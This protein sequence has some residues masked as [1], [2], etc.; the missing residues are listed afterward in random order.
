MSAPARAN[1]AIGAAKAAATP[2]Q[3]HSL[4]QHKCACG[5]SRSPLADACE[6]CQSHALQRK[7]LVGSSTDPFELEADRVAEQVLRRQPAAAGATP[8]SIRRVPVHSGVS[9][10]GPADP[11]RVDRVDPQDGSA[12]S[13]EKGASCGTPAAHEQDP[14]PRDRF[15]STGESAEALTPFDLTSGGAPLPAPLR[16]L[17]E[18]RFGRDLGEV[19]LHTGPLAAARTEQLNARAFTYASH[20]WLGQGERPE[21]GFLLAHELAHVIQQRQPAPLAAAHGGA[22]AGSGSA[23]L[24][25]QRRFIKDSVPFWVPLGPGGAM[26]GQ[27]LHNLVLTGAQQ[28]NPDL[29][30]EVDAPNADTHGAGV[31][32]R[33]RIDLYRSAPIHKM[34]GY[35]FDGP[36][37]TTDVMLTTAKSFRGAAGGTN[38][39]FRPYLAGNRIEAL[40]EGPTSVE[41]GELKPASRPMLDAGKDQLKDYQSGMRQAAD[42]TNEWARLNNVRD[43]Q[44]SPAEWKLHTIRN[45]PGSAVPAIPPRNLTRLVV[46]DIRES[47]SR[48][49][50]YQVKIRPAWV[51]GAI[52]VRGRVHVQ[53]YGKDTGLWMYYALPENLGPLLGTLQ[54]TQI[55]GEIEVANAVQDQVID[56]LTQAA[57]Y[58]APLLRDRAD[59]VDRPTVRRKP[60][61][62]QPPGKFTD[63]F[64]LSHWRASRR[65]LHG[66]LEHP[67]GKDK[68]KLAALDL[69]DGVLAADET[70]TGLG[71]PSTPALPTSK[72]KGELI[73]VVSGS[74]TKKNKK[75]HR[76]SLGDLRPWLA[77]WT[78]P[79]SDV[80]GVFRAAFGGMF[81]RVAQLLSGIGKSDLLA[82]LKKRVVDLFAAIK[83][84]ADRSA[85][86]TVMKEGLKWAVGKVADLLLPSVFRMV[87]GAI[88]TGIGKALADLFDR[89]LVKQAHEEFDKW[90]QTLE[91][92]EKSIHSKIDG[93]L[94]LFQE[95]KDLVSK[96]ASIAEMVSRVE[97]GIKWGIRL[98]EC[99]GVWSC[100][101]VLL[102]PVL[103]KLEDKAILALKDRIL[104]ACGVRSLLAGSVRRVL[105]DA[106]VFIANKILSFLH[107]LVPES[108]PPLRTVFAE[109]VTPEPPPELKEMEDNDCWGIDLGFSF[110][111]EGF[112]HNKSGADK[113][114]KDDKQDDKKSSAPPV[115]PG[116]TPPPPKTT[117]PPP[118]ATPSPRTTAPPSPPSPPKTTA[119]QTPPA[120]K[121]APPPPPSAPKQPPSAKP[122]DTSVTGRIPMRPWDASAMKI[123]LGVAVSA[124]DASHVYTA[125]SQREHTRQSKVHPEYRLGYC[126]ASGVLDAQVY[127]WMDEPDRGRPKP[128][129]LPT[130]SIRWKAGKHQQEASDSNPVYTPPTPALTGWGQGPLRPSFGTDFKIPVADNDTVVFDLTLAD[131]DSGVT[132]IYHDSLKV[133]SIPCT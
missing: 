37:G 101:L 103:D 82:K 122:P 51:R 40:E 31:H 3:T 47:G 113:G 32:H 63:T 112:T 6:S 42:L 11:S 84:K 78:G 71:L 116:D 124:T 39:R 14:H 73:N 48:G 106:P 83:L 5:A 67:T 8:L 68:Q 86:L 21:P 34:P 52:D 100:V 9:L 85:I 96:L 49:A 125:E 41:L 114:G 131:K 128:F 75:V 29:D 109:K 28:A 91:G 58:Q 77:H 80:L 90:R 62:D 65:K 1:V 102:G 33:G 97:S 66:Q 46:A 4:F 15:D 16:A 115:A 93:I 35:W 44:G 99:S 133:T 110:F 70:L 12:A 111:D 19:R 120:T 76:R 119:P 54:G 30:R 117:A 98:A 64:V 10:P 45:L 23:A 88:H 57:T 94:T 13:A 20:I 53:P 24:H 126:V 60:K 7:V 22:P 104:S 38:E 89:D 121:P 69:I 123:E 72:D 56:P 26:S 2:A 108:L 132:L 87:A 81:V 107:D 61:Y 59:V 127:F 43:A 118:P 130:A 27:E 74:D 92:I 18:P 25:V 79:L 50:K 55:G 36:P 129:T 95:A 17:F 105:V